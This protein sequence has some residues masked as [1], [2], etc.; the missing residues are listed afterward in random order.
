MEI[1]SGWREREPEVIG[2][3]H[4]HTWASEKGKRFQVST[5]E[6][7]LCIASMTMLY[8]WKIGNYLPSLLKREENLGIFS[9][10]YYF[11]LHAI[12]TDH[13]IKG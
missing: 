12:C 13:L 8:H 4:A 6:K 7:F 2:S 11:L 10:Y 5:S 1:G 9:E 3:K